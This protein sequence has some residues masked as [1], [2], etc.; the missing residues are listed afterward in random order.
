MS[1]PFLPQFM[2]SCDWCSDSVSPDDI[3]FCHKGDF[4]CESCAAEKQL[5][6]VCGNYKKDQYNNCYDCHELQSSK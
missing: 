1:N 6:C 4:I 2:S 3:M 5:I